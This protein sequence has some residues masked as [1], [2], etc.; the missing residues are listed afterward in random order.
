MLDVV[1][2]INLFNKGYSRE[3]IKLV[4]SA[5]KDKGLDID[6]QINVFLELANS[7]RDES[8]LAAVVQDNLGFMQSNIRM[9]VGIAPAPKGVVV[10]Y[11]GEYVL[12]GSVVK[13]TVTPAAP[14]VDEAKFAA[15][16]PDEKQ[17]EM[18]RTL[19]NAHE[20]TKLKE[21][22]PKGEELVIKLNE[23]EHRLRRGEHF[24]AGLD[25]V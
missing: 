10:I 20:L 11:D 4:Q 14:I 23:R 13:I 24:F 21:R 2:D 9:P 7:N 19:L 16:V 3:I 15:L 5:R 17:R 12:D 22:V 18:L 25:D 6:D 8:R 1:E